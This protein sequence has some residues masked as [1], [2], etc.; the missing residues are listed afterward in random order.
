M[1]DLPGNRKPCPLNVAR[2]LGVQLPKSSDLPSLKVS[3]RTDREVQVG[4]R[5]IRDLLASLGNNQ[6][7]KN[8]EAK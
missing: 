2:I 4:L 3:A 5:S 1:Q 8:D 7:Q 6:N